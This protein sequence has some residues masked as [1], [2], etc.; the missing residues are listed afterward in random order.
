MQASCFAKGSVR[1][2]DADRERTAGLLRAHYAVGRLDLDELERR[3]E[4]AWAAVYRRDLRALLRD[5]PLDL[6]MHAVRRF[7]RFQRQALNVH[8][9]LYGTASTA[10]VGTWTLADGGAFWPAWIA[11]PGAVLLGWHAAGSRALRRTLEDDRRR[12]RPELGARRVA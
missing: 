5:L 11:L 6:R 7:Y 3:L 2:S 12:A 8:A 10:A 4:R 9:A 1:V